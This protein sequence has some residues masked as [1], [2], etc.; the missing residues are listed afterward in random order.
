MFRSQTKF[1]TEEEILEAFDKMKML[2]DEEE[3]K[4]KEE[5]KR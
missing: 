5:E 1:K 4:R 2:E 3:K